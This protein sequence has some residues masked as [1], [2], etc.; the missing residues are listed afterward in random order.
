MVQDCDDVHMSVTTAE[1]G[2]VVPPPRDR[3]RIVHAVLVG[4]AALLLVVGLGGG[5]NRVAAHRAGQVEVTWAGG[6]ECAGAE[7]VSYTDDGSFGETPWTGPL[8]RARRGMRC[9]VT[10]EITNRGGSSVHLDHASLP[11]LGPG[12]GSVVRL[13]P[14]VDPVLWTATSSAGSDIDAVRTLDTTL[15]PDEVAT[16]D[17]PLAFRN[18]GCSGG[19][20]GQTFLYGFPAVTV[21]TLLFSFERP[22]ADDLAFSQA[23]PAAGCAQSGS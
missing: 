22:A 5:W 12:G 16:F 23:G 8:I 4:V 21:R 19:R 6:P 2:T 7:V 9:V 14:S 15:E 18:H 17:V 20:G 11:F 13:A 1:S 10:V 3:R